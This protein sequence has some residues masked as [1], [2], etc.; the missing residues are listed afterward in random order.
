MVIAKPKLIKLRNYNQNGVIAFVKIDFKYTYEDDIEK[1]NMAAWDKLAK[2]IPNFTIPPYYHIEL[3]EGCC[4]IPNKIFSVTID[5]ITGNTF[6]RDEVIPMSDIGLNLD[7]TTY[8]DLG[9]IDARN[10]SSFNVSDIYFEML[11]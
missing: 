7:G 4:A 5:P 1:S 8:S 9:T 10:I 3:P 2:S 6:L 11:L